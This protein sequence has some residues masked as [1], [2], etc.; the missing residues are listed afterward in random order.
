LWPL[1][2]HFAR[3]GLNWTT[4]FIYRHNAVPKSLPGR[5]RTR[6]FCPRTTAP[7]FHRLC[8]FQRTLHLDT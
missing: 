4:A 3:W 5:I 1:E 6:I 2:R 8:I 7:I